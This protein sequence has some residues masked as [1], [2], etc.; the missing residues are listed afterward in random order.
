[1]TELVFEL[2]KSLLS[3]DRLTARQLLARQQAT[4]SS[5]DTVEQL[6]VPVLERIGNGW[7]AGNIA[8]SQVYMS[9]R[10]CEE[11]VD[12][13]LPPGDP[14]RKD[15][16]KLGLAVLEDYHMLG[17]RIVYAVLRAGGFEVID[18]GR[19]TVSE[20]VERVQADRVKI[21]LIS[22]LMLPSA[23]RVK[24][25]R[26]KLNQAGSSVKIVVGGAPFLFDETLWQE[27]QADAM[28]A[29]ASEVL[30]I[31]SRLGDAA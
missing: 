17:K 8:L 13:L 25:V 4:T 5:F 30:E 6:I 3:L 15:L 2:E 9:G 23:L 28:A 20:L 14:E 31:I 21:L 27:V 29:R 12:E 10:I 1:L 26:K 18:Y 24:E 7:T 16:P 22:T 19:V 11:L